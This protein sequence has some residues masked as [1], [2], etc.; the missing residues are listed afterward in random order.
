MMSLF[1]TL[2]IAFAFFATFSGPS[3][4]EQYG[5]RASSP[6]LFSAFSSLFLHA[7]VFHLLGNMLFLVGV[8]SA[9]EEDLGAIKFS[10]VYLLGGL[11]GVLVHWWLYRGNFGGPLLLGASG[12]IASCVGYCGIRFSA[13]K[14]PLFY[15]LSIPVWAMVALWAIL[16]VVSLFY[17]VSETAPKVAFA[18]HLGGFAFGLLMTFVFRASSTA[19][20]EIASQ[21]IAQSQSQ[22]LEASLE[23]TE[24]AL[25]LKPNDPD[26]LFSAAEITRS[27]GET[28]R[29]RQYLDRLWKVSPGLAAQR[30]SE[31]GEL[32]KIPSLDR[33]KAQSNL[34]PMPKTV[35]LE[36]VATQ[37]EDPECPNAMLELALL[38]QKSDWASKLLSQFPMHPASQI[39]QTR[40]LK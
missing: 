3:S 12:C 15:G 1:V 36:S 20:V 26:L 5:F 22:G 37:I 28:A 10:L 23:A 11:F 8:G 35:I 21:H 9:L 29:E 18:A 13:R 2:N 25:K 30:L 16:Q 27:I 34:D 39:A 17:S 14:A 31:I 4:W 33:M 40:G 32:S 7:N 19:K 6:S 38:D 24:N